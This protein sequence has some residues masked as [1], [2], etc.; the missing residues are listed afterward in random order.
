MTIILL[1]KGYSVSLVNSRSLDG[2]NGRVQN[3]IKV[4]SPRKVTEPYYFIFVSYIFVSISSIVK[5]FFG[6][7]YL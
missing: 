2:M 7:C 4:C 3:M 6:M 1:D 5:G